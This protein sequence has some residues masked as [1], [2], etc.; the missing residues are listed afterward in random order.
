MHPAVTSYD[1]ISAQFVQFMSSSI[2]AGHL[3]VSVE[4]NEHS[5]GQ[6]K[7]LELVFLLSSLIAAVG[8]RESTFLSSRWAGGCLGSRARPATVNNEDLEE[9][10]EPWKAVI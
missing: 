5:N 10:F 4:H 7:A 9:P 8:Q 2:C 6:D 1:S 3:C